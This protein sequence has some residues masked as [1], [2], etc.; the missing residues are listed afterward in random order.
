MDAIKPIGYTRV[1][2]ESQEEYNTLYIVDEQTEAGNVMISVWKPT[3]D[4]VKV[5]NEGGSVCLGIIG[6]SH[7]PVW[8][9]AQ[10]HVEECSTENISVTIDD[11]E[12]QR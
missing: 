6:T 9:W 7:P 10:G 5:I 3:A 4:E 12:C 1:L 8:V 2:A 11:T